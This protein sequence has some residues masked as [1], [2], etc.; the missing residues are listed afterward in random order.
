MTTDKLS[1]GMTL[2]AFGA[3]RYLI[4]GEAVDISRAERPVD[5][6]SVETDAGTIVLDAN[7]TAV[8]VIDMQ[9]DFCAEGS[10]LHIAGVEMKGMRESI[11]RANEK[12]RELC[13]P[14]IWVNWG[15]RPDLHYVP[16]TVQFPFHQLGRGVGLSMPQ[17]ANAHAIEAEGAECLRKTA[18]GR[19]S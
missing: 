1:S 5:R 14:V 18:G 7:K 8:V 10:W 9:N 3:D 6:V 13:R 19:R 16:A 11:N 4:S 15:N 17:P 12:L 2:C